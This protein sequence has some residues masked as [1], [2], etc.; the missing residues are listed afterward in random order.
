MLDFG[1]ATGKCYQ[2]LTQ[3]QKFIFD[4]IGKYGIEW[5]VVSGISIFKGLYQSALH[6]IWGMGGILTLP[7]VLKLFF[8]ILLELKTFGKYFLYVDGQ[9]YQM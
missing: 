7:F 1:K 5:K 6:L 2:L 8:T 9:V 3:Q 4:V